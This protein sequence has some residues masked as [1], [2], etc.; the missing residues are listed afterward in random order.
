MARLTQRQANLLLALR[1]QGKS[2]GDADAIGQ[3]LGYAYPR[4]ACDR[5]VARGLAEKV[6][7]GIYRPRVIRE[8]KP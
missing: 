1:W 3:L 7:P 4:A 2:A 8:R 5:L 6:A